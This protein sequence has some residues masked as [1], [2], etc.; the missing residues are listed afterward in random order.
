MNNRDIKQ[1]RILIELI[2]RNIIKTEVTEQGMSLLQ[3]SE[4]KIYTQNILKK[5]YG[6]CRM[7]CQNPYE[8]YDHYTVDYNMDKNDKFSDHNLANLLNNERVLNIEG[9]RLNF[10]NLTHDEFKN[11]LL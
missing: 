8:I 11:I 9:K 6:I 2:T 10:P 3:D 7:N 1:T 4:R 5:K